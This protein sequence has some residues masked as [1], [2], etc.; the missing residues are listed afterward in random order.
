MPLVGGPQVTSMAGFPGTTVV[1]TSSGGLSG[2][3]GAAA[4]AE[5][6]ASRWC[7]IMC[8]RKSTSG[9]PVNG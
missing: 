5:A 1:C 9:L 3:R 8:T 7:G 2:S 4:C 6:T